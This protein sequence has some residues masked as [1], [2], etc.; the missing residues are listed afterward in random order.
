MPRFSRFLPALIGVCVLSFSVASAAEADRKLP[1]PAW[2]PHY[3]LDMQVDVDG[4]KVHVKERVTWTNRHKRPTTELVF[5]VHS[6]YSIP[7]DG[8]G[9]AAKTIEL[10]RVNPSEALDSVGH[11]VEMKSASLGKTPLTYRWDEPTGTALVLPLP[12]PVVENQSVTVDLDFVFHLPQKQGRWG[13]FD[14]ITYLSNWLPV[15]AVYDDKG[16]QPTPFIP[17][18]QPF[19]N[20]SGIYTVKVVLPIDQ[21]VGC[22]GSIVKTRKLDERLQQ[23]DIKADGIRD[24][25]FLCSDRFQEITSEVCGV[26]VHVLAFPEHQHYAE[27]I[28]RIVSEAIPVYTK[29]FGPYAWPDFTVCEACFPWNGNECATLVMIDQRVFGMPHL[30]GGYVEYLVSHETCHQWWYNLIGTNGYCETWMDEAMATH[31]AH[32]LLND[33]HGKNNPLMHYPGG[34]GW[35][36]NIHREDYRLYSMYA[37]LGRGDQYPCVQELDKYGHVVNLFSTVYDRGGKVVGMIEERLG[38]AAFFDFMHRIYQRYGYRILRVA[39]FQ[40]ELEEYTGQSWQEFFDRWLCG[41]G[42]TDWA[43]EKVDVKEQPGGGCR[44]CTWV[45]DFLSGLHASKQNDQPCTVTVILH[46][47]ADYDEPTWLGICLDDGKGPKGLDPRT[48]PCQIRIPIDPQVESIQLNDPPCV[49]E[50]LPDH[51]VRVTVE[52]PSR[53]VQIAVDPDQVLV[54]KDPSNNFWKSPIRW[55][56]TPVYTFLEETPLTTAFDRWNVIVGPWLFSPIYQDPWYTQSTMIGARAGLYRTEEFKGGTYAAYRTD[57][58]DFVAGLDGVWMHTPFPHTEIGFNV[59]QRLFTF[60][61]GNSDAHPNRAVLY[62]RYI[63]QYGSSL[64]LPPMEYADAFTTYQQNFL[65]FERTPLPGAE[66]YQHEVLGGLHYHYDYLTPYWDPEGGVKFDATYEGGYGKFNQNLG[67]HMLSGQVSTVKSVPDVSGWVEDHAPGGEWL[68]PAFRWL[69]DTKLAFRAY[70]AAGLPSQGEL[71][72]LGGDALFRGFD[73]NE[74]QGNIVWVGSVEWRIP[75]M[76]NVCYDTLDHVMG[77]RNVYG[78]LFYDVGDCYVNGGHT[79]GPVAHAVGVGLR[80]DTAWFSFVE[81]N[82]LCFDIAKTVNSDR[83][84]Q[85]YFSAQLPF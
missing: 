2:L 85:F 17:W 75:L 36:P 84:V 30:A 52:L 65:P 12:K 79:Y 21:K 1:L 56:I 48:R 77:V 66:R 76:K 57:F 4:H 67:V 60:E 63:M 62:G 7:K 14:G 26:K 20:E 10:L 37:A 24:F 13:Q 45:P 15:L 6:N 71:F 39:D 16:W 28:Q 27:E 9:L 54:D 78:A 40:R 3:D 25:A 31:F 51:H 32:K 73:L 70:G 18:H 34:L 81:R 5:N 46:Q 83:G 35:V 22:S 43:V 61:S 8:I 38:E 59:E 33:K 55:R 53:P 11:P 19:F 64:Y 69:S 74:R 29:W 80:L 50:S 58:R 44:E 47:K 42:L 68:A 41:K 23:V 49:V 82:M 72:T